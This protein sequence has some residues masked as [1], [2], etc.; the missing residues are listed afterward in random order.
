MKWPLIAFFIIEFPSLLISIRSV[1]ESLLKVSPIKFYSNVAS[2][3]VFELNLL[4]SAILIKAD[5]SRG[6]RV[7]LC[8]KFLC[9]NMAKRKLIIFSKI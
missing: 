4:A 9:H 3:E 5:E 6:K 1:I 8:Q 2:R 7:D